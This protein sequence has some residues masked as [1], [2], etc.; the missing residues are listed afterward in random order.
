MSVWHQLV[1]QW[2]DFLN[3]F[4][5]IMSTSLKYDAENMQMTVG[6]FVMYNIQ[7]IVSVQSF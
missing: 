2:G 5:L 7:Q 3:T 6:D 4:Y 1:V